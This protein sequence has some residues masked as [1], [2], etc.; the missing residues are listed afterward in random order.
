MVFIEGP[1]DESYHQARLPRSHISKKDQLRLQANYIA[2][3]NVERELRED[4]FANVVSEKNNDARAV[5]RSAVKLAERPRVPRTSPWFAHAYASQAA[6]GTE[7]LQPHHCWRFR[8]L[9]N[10]APEP[11]K[12]AYFRDLCNVQ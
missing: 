8:H 12:S 5:L 11:T 6:D 10:G 4:P 2:D 9:F 3:G 7:T 1:L